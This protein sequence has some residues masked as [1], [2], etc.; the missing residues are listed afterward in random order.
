MRCFSAIRIIIQLLL[1]LLSVNIGLT[2]VDSPKFEVYTVQAGQTVSSIAEEYGIPATTLA[3]FNKIRV[4]TPLKADMILMVPISVEAALPDMQSAAVPA[5]KKAVPYIVGGVYTINGNSLIYV[6]AAVKIIDG[7]MTID[8]K[9]RKIRITKGDLS[10]EA[11]MNKYGNTFIPLREFL[12]KFE[13]N[14]DNLCDNDHGIY[15]KRYL[16][17]D[18]QNQPVVAI[19]MALE[20]ERIGIFAMFIG[21]TLYSPDDHPYVL[22]AIELTTGTK[23]T[24]PIDWYTTQEPID[25]SSITLLMRSAEGIEKKLSVKSAYDFVYNCRWNPRSKNKRLRE[26][27]AQQATAERARAQRINDIQRRHPTWK[28]KFIVNALDGYIMVGM[29]ADLVILAWGPPNERNRTVLYGMVSEQWVYSSQ[30][31]YVYIDNGICVGWQ[32]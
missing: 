22:K 29:P 12:K 25:G 17:T 27:K 19:D 26:R 9:A 23:L 31:T 24:S 18:P 32:D 20:D 6:R 15:S 16:I 21:K 1:V 10:Y 11:D 4:D 3:E 5:I 13:Y 2:A 7:I 14:I 28:R 8:A 30:D